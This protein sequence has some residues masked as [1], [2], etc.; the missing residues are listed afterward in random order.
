MGKEV[1]ALIFR[2]AAENP[3]WGAPRIHGELLK[4]GFHLSEAT[5]SRWLRRI[6]RTPDPAKRWLI[7]L[8]NHREA[9]AAMDFFTVPTLT[10]GILYCFFVIGHDRRKVL[11]F[12]VTRNPNALWIVQQLVEAWPY[13]PAHRFLL[14]DHDSKFGTDVIAAVRHLGSQPIRTAFRSPWQNGFAE[15]WVGSCRRDL[16]DHMIAGAK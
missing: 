13:V 16:L 3:T 2:I 14:F 15:R 8:R 4:L 12:N 1:R 10:F 7:F 6:P 5:V 11:R 9:I